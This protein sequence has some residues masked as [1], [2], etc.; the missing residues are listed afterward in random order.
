MH[1][2]IYYSYLKYTSN[3]SKRIESREREIMNS[4]LSRKTH[5]TH[6]KRINNN[7]KEYSNRYSTFTRQGKA[8]FLMI[9]FI[10]YNIKYNSLID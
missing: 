7:N 9:I 8:Y 2:I 5:M 10:L 3:N 6:I 4:K 1:L